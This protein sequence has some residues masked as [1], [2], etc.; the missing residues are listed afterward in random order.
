MTLLVHWLHNSKQKVKSN[1]AT[2]KMSYE[3]NIP[4]TILPKERF[5]EEER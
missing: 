2:T 3:I 4:G 5:R 1:F